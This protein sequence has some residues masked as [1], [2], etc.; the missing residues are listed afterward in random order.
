MQPLGRIEAINVGRPIF[1]M[2]GDLGDTVS[3]QSEALSIVHP[4]T[5]L[6]LVGNR[7]SGSIESADTRGGVTTCGSRS[8]RWLCPA[9][10]LPGI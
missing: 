1:E 5:I 7:E 3:E 4:L 2:E 10:H 8:P 9:G 6:N